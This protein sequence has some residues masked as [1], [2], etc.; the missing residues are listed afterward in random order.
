MS[1]SKWK[2]I[3]MR[4]CMFSYIFHWQFFLFFSVFQKKKQKNILNWFSVMKALHSNE[5]TMLDDIY[6][7]ESCCTAINYIY[8]LWNS[9]SMKILYIDWV[10]IRCVIGIKLLG[11]TCAHQR[12]LCVTQK[13]KKDNAHRCAVHLRRY[14]APQ[15]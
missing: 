14:I 10:F 13:R 15:A 2:L 8:N 5:H 6:I 11:I 9:L 1:T 12:T 7:Q 4:V 3:E